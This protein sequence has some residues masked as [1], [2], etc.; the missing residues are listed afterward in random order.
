MMSTK[1]LATA[2]MWAALVGALLTA[3][4]GSLTPNDPGYRTLTVVLAVVTALAVYGVPN[5]DE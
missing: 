5:R 4:V 1:F 3:L 2:K